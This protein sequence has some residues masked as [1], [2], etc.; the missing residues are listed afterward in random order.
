MKFCFDG[1]DDCES[2]SILLNELPFN[3]N[4]DPES[5]ENRRRKLIVNPDFEEEGSD[6]P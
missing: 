1:K 2:H 3:L 4:P 5:E 6:E